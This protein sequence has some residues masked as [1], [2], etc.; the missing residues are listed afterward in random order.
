[1]S[2]ASSRYIKIIITE[3]DVIFTF[4][5]ELDDHNRQDI[6]RFAED[7]SSTEEI[8][9]EDGAVIRIDLLG[10]FSLATIDV[11]YNSVRTLNI[12]YF[13]KIFESDDVII[14]R[15]NI[16]LEFVALK[17]YGIAPGIADLN[18]FYQ[19]KIFNKRNAMLLDVIDKKNEKIFF[20]HEEANRIVADV[21]R[22]KNKSLFMTT[23]IDFKI[24]VDEFSLSPEIK[25]I[26][27]CTNSSKFKLDSSISKKIVKFAGL[28]LGKIKE[29]DSYKAK[30]SFSNS[31][32][33]LT[34]FTQRADT[35]TIKASSSKNYS[36]AA[37]SISKSHD[38]KIKTEV[39]GIFSA[40]SEDN[41][42]LID[43]VQ[44]IVIYLNI[45][46]TADII[47]E[48]AKFLSLDIIARVI[49][50]NKKEYLSSLDSKIAAAKNRDLFLTEC[51][52]K[53]LNKISIL[54]LDV[55][56]Y[57]TDIRR[58]VY[59]DNRA[60]EVNVPFS[61]TDN[62]NKVPAITNIRVNLTVLEYTDRLRSI[63]ALE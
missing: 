23:Q 53:D 5:K 32:T 46:A 21:R 4:Y 6:F 42:E 48:G 59:D 52:I 61:S 37:S 3:T 44:N 60:I 29:I 27:N 13:I 14:K 2:L 18:N 57:V 35:V 11:N 10:I 34:I 58:T 39:L 25:Y 20:S 38:K 56:E 12:K 41:D 1:M 47:C 33:I 7:K 36:V 51:I 63:V 24:I 43:N 55:N 31:G 16:I 50:L 40:T 28:S 54:N 8:I 19:S 30:I 15:K 22:A 49:A 9:D 26:V 62:L 45:F 17:I